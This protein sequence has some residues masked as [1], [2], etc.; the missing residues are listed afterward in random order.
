MK[1]RL[2]E[3]KRRQNVFIILCV[4]TKAQ[5]LSALCLLIGKRHVCGA[6][7]SKIPSRFSLSQSVRPPTCRRHAADKES[8]GFRTDEAIISR[9]LQQPVFLATD[10]ANKT[11]CE[12]TMIS[13]GCRW[14]SQRALGCRERARDSAETRKMLCCSGNSSH[15]PS[16]TVEWF[17]SGS[18]TAKSSSALLLLGSSLCKMWLART[19]VHCRHLCDDWFTL[20]N[21]CNI[22]F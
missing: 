9:W 7:E 10:K 19:C 22:I 2:D 21:F 4:Q 1:N 14:R 16:S 8:G 11:Q 13:N 20:N 18:R 12:R 5:Q 3:R 15:I 17:H 6:H